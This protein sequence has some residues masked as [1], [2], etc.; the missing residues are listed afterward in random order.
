MA[1][2]FGEILSELVGLI[3][4]AVGAI[5]LD[6]EGEAV[7]QFG[8]IPEFDIKF[9]GAHWGVVLNHVRRVLQH[10]RYGRV[11]HVFLGGEMVDIIIKPVTR[12][13]YIVLTMKHGSHLATAFRELARVTT[14][15]QKA[16]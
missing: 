2:E 9:S 16:M 5:F 1:S 15:I 13:Y 14:A 7:D 4:G 10:G 8:H 3:P 11:E 6:W 12:E